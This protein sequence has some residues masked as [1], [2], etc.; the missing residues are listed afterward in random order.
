MLN[1]SLRPH[2]LLLLASLFLSATIVLAQDPAVIVYEVQEEPWS[3][4]IEALGTLRANETVVLT[5]SVTDTITRINFEDGERVAKGFVLAEMTDSEES[6]LVREMTIRLNEAKK[7][8]DRLKNLPKSGAISASL[9]DEKKKEFEAA[10]AQLEAMKSRLKDRLIV[11]PFAGV[12]GLRNISAGALV[13]PGDEIT[14]LSDDSVMKLDFTVPSVFLSSLELELPISATTKAYPGKKFSGKVTA[15]DS[16]IDPVTRSL[17][18]RAKIPNDDTLLKPGL[19]MSVVLEY[20]HRTTPVIP[21][22]A[23]MPLQGSYSVFLYDAATRSVLKTPVETGGRR[24]GYVEI[25]AGLKTNDMVVTHG[26][27]VARDGQAVTIKATQKR[28]SSIKAMISSGA[29]AG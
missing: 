20:K 17:T 24:K 22:E 8:F 6:A 14:T 26:T 2:V 4:S 19:M 21:E 28:G 16:R 27:Q 13:V 1:K 9:Y 7:Q 11:A 18:V 15:I 25:T 10:M 5:A 29:D 3:D 12:V 23:L